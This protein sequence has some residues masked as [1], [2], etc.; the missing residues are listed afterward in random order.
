M[1]A[2]LKIGLQQIAVF[3]PFATL[4]INTYRILMPL[5]WLTLFTALQIISILSFCTNLVAGDFFWCMLAVGVYLILVIPVYVRLSEKTLIID[6]IKCEKLVFKN[7]FTKCTQAF[8]SDYRLSLVSKI[9]LV[10]QVLVGGSLL[11][12]VFGADWFLHGLAGF[13]I[14]AIAMKAYTI[15]VNFYGYGRLASYFH[16]DRYRLLRTQRKYASAEFTLFSV[17]LIAL[18]WELFEN[19]V[20]WFSPVNVFRVNG[21]P[22]WNTFGDVFFAVTAGMVAWYL[23]YRKVKWL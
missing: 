20:Y 8:F 10:F 17:T 22:V 16:V 4:A 13:G 19:I 7:L 15:G 2:P 18:L 1:K 9:P 11:Y 6:D 23:L 3:I 14:G 12:G 21:E 5:K